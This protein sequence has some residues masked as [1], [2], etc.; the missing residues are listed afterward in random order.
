VKKLLIFV[1]PDDIVYVFLFSLVILID[2]GFLGGD[3]NCGKG[4]VAVVGWAKDD[5]KMKMVAVVATI[6]IRATIWKHFSV[7]TNWSD[8]VIHIYVYLRRRQFD[9]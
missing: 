8:K 3:G 9:V 6:E 5:G 7:S 4:F 1:N 2:A